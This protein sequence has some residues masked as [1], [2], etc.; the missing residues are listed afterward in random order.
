MAGLRIPQRGL[1]AVARPVQ[2][3][4]LLA[5]DLPVCG[6]CRSGV[7]SGAAHGT[8]HVIFEFVCE[9]RCALRDPQVVTV[10]RRGV[11]EF[12]GDRGLAQLV[13]CTE[14]GRTKQ[15]RLHRGIQ[16]LVD[17][18]QRGR[19][20]GQGVGVCSHEAQGFGGPLD[21][22][23]QFLA[24]CLDRRDACRCLLALGAQ[25]LDLGARLGQ[26]ALDGQGL[27]E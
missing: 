19:G 6:R 10:R 18:A 11:R 26:R 3:G 12:R 20:L 16:A 23:G 4:D 13:R 1:R 27:L 14:E 21:R 22:E 7:L 5:R 2:L 15:V 17:G 24:L 8:G 9:S 25:R